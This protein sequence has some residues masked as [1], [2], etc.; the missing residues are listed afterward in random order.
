MFQIS[1]TKKGLIV[2]NNADLLLLSGK[3]CKKPIEEKEDFQIGNND[4]II[5]TTISLKSF[6][7]KLVYN[8]VFL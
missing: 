2:D 3:N 4:I 6:I 7:T 5:Y 8:S 1:S